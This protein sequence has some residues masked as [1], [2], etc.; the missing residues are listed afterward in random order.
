MTRPTA[1]RE[2]H[3]HLPAHGREMGYLALGDCVDRGD[4]LDRVARHAADLDRRAEPGWLL[5]SG[6]RPESWA[7]APGGAAWPTRDE[8]D[9]ACPRRPCFVG[10]F[11]HHSCA[12]NS[13]ALAASGF[14][15]ASPDPEGG[16]IA[17]D[18]RG[19][20]TGVLLESAYGAARAAIPEPTRP[21]WKRFIKAAADHLASLGFVEVHDLLTPPGLGSILAELHD[22]GALPVR[23]LLY[24]PWRELDDEVAAAGSYRRAGV[25]L[26]GGKLFADGTLN[27]A[28]AWMLHPYRE[29]VAGMLHG[30]P[31][32]APAELDEALAACQA[33]GLELAVHAI[34]D[35][36][37]RATL[38]ARAR[39]PAA[40]LRIEHAEL[41]DRADVPRFA[42]LG[43]TCSVQPCHLLYDAE[44]LRRRCP[45]RLD[46]VLPLRE[47]IDSGCGP[48]GLLWFGSDTPIVRP[49][50][51]D[52]IAAAVQRRRAQGSPAG[53]ACDPVA[54]EQAI[55]EGEAWACFGG[56]EQ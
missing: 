9:R 39:R 45:D 49:D 41:I 10:A 34:G 29:P 13:A 53:P 31:L 15:D 30:K 12:L 37:V 5:A 16:V 47:L 19:R 46:R 55:T 4:A 28:T 54:P 1:L 8:L 7:S 11:D 56:S 26:A 38:D 24:R 14:H 33:R 36:A 17:R 27:A 22:E 44:A 18:A 43:V 3:A 2:A 42:E 51:G 25:D 40:R 48:G 52:S 6:L 20:A 50:P 21:Q 32:A 23:V 35:A